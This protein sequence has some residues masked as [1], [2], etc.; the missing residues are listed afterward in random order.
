MFKIIKSIFSMPLVIVLLLFFALSSAVAT[1]IENDFG[2]LGAKSF[3]YGQ[4]WFE[5]I[6]LLLTVAVTINIFVFKMYKKERFFLFMIHISLV[7]IFIG[8]ALTRYMGYEANITIYEGLTENKMYSSDEYIKVFKDKELIYDKK[9]LM[10]KLSQ[11]SFNY[12]TEVEN[13]KVK[14]NFNRYIENA[15]E[16]IVPGVLSKV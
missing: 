10:T 11:T 12:E 2:P 14:V 15:V 3:I 8:S 5:L 7:F 1:F 13:E 4:T 6:M 9:V 16:K